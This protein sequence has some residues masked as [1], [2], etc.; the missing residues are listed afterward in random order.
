M[1]LHLVRKV[2][3]A[4][5]GLIELTSDKEKGTTFTLYFPIAPSGD[6]QARKKAAPPSRDIGKRRI[7]VVDDEEVVRGLLE[8][9]LTPAGF[10]VLLAKDGGEA[11]DVFLNQNESIDLVLL[12]MIMP[13]MKGEE[14]LKKL[15][16]QSSAVK[17]IVSSGYMTEEQR[18]KLQEY[19]VDG[20]LDKPYG[21]ADAVNIVVSVLTGHAGARPA[22]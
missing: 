18:E 20:F 16:E 7:L 9:V 13:G 5:D 12:D 15:R 1:G 14:V 4:H 3:K 10:E 2:I 19:R 22:E 11:I 17:V 6:E 21:D 8:G